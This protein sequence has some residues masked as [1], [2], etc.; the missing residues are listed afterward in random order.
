M[1]YQNTLSPSYFKSP[2]ISFIYESATHNLADPLFI[3]RVIAMMI[4]KSKGKTD[5]SLLVFFRESE[6]SHHSHIYGRDV[7]CKCVMG[8]L[9]SSFLGNVFPGNNGGRVIFFL[10]VCLAILMVP[11]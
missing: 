6:K 7:L 8:L 10:E 11:A 9:F 4:T 5:S 1:K 3:R 2:G